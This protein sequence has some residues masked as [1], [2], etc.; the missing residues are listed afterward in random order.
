MKLHFDNA[1]SYERSC[2]E[3]TIAVKFVLETSVWTQSVTNAEPEIVAQKIHAE[4]G[5]PMFR[6]AFVNHA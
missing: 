2:I 1:E 5:F 4:W 3:Q 6:I